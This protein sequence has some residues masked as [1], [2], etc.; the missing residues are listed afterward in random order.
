MT[1]IIKR[2]ID[3]FWA[4]LA[5]VLIAS[6]ALVTIVR[7]LLP[8][9]GAQRAGIESWIEETVGRPVIV[10]EIEASW[11]G[12]SPRI[13]V[14]DIAFF[15]PS[16]TS[17]LVRFDR[18]EIS[19]APLG[20]IAARA[21]K[22][23]SLIVSGVE[24][25]LIRHRDGRLTVAGM[26]PPKSPIIVWLLK[27]NNF[28][29]TEADLSVIDVRG[30]AT[31]ALSNVTVA[32]QNRGNR[33]FLSGYVNLPDSIGGDLSFELSSIGNPLESDW[34]GMVNFRL[35]DIRSAYVAERLAWHGGR[36]PDTPVDLVAWT[37]WQDGR[38]E[39]AAFDLRV[40]DPASGANAGTASHRPR[41][42]RTRT[43]AATGI[44]LANR[45]RPTRGAGR[46]NAGGQHQF[47]RLR[48]IRRRFARI[49]S[50]ER[51]GNATRTR[52]RARRAHAADVRCAASSAHRG[53]SERCS[54]RSGGRVGRCAGCGAALF[55]RTPGSSTCHS[56]AL[57]IR[58]GSRAS[59]PA[60][61]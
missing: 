61:S 19:I 38:L 6:A 20:S 14:S 44:R 35:N 34:D 30:G 24:L 57:K 46:G 45:H 9:V 43:P 1:G 32:V 11:R 12:W 4:A 53:S 5:A 17:E 26:P 36:P 8:E 16:E 50:L 10:G 29:V 21:L 41:P 39:R 42:E 7:M 2:S 51:S 52:R 28:A 60:W 58:Q 25:S 31:F 54:R 47:Q 40:P 23:K 33:K 27:Q 56:T 55:T 22:P 49:G 48:R 37:R 18:A 59:M 3:F 13:S 15:D